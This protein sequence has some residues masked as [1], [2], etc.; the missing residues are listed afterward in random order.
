MPFFI[1]NKPEERQLSEYVK[2]L[3][4]AMLFLEIKAKESKMS[5][6]QLLD[7]FARPSEDS[8]VDRLEYDLVCEFQR[9]RQGCPD[10]PSVDC[11]RTA[12]DSVR[13]AGQRVLIYNLGYYEDVP[14]LLDVYNGLASEKEARRKADEEVRAVIAARAAKR[15][16]N[17]LRAEKAGNIEAEGEG[18]DR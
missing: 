16:A 8:W 17:R 1:I 18:A 13:S 9:W 15:V 11:F 12:L 14:E 4:D 3:C 10:S 7:W 6:N 2:Y 5:F